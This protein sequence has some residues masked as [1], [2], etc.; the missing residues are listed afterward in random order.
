MG[1]WTGN[2]VIDFVLN[3][4]LIVVVVVLAVWAVK[5]IIG[6]LDTALIYPH[7]EGLGPVSAHRPVLFERCLFAFLVCVVFG[8]IA[9]RYL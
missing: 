4:I 2:G 7:Y 3:L 1:R 9:A 8:A 5:E 6:A